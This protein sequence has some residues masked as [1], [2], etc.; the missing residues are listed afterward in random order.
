MAHSNS[1]DRHLPHAQVLAKYGALCRLLLRLRR[2]AEMLDDAWAA[3]RAGGR[4]GLVSRLATRAG[5]RSDSPRCTTPPPPWLPEPFDRPACTTL[6][7]SSMHSPN[8]KKSTLNS[9]STVN[10][11]QRPAERGAGGRCCR[12]GWCDRWRQAPP[13]AARCGSCARRWRT[14]SRTSSATCRCGC[15][16]TWQQTPGV[17]T[18]GCGGTAAAAAS[19]A[20]ACCLP[21]PLACHYAKGNQYHSRLPLVVSKDTACAAVQLCQG[22]TPSWLLLQTGAEAVQEH[23]QPVQGD[24]VIRLAGCCLVSCTQQ[25]APCKH[26]DAAVPA[27]HAAHLTR[28]GRCNRGGLPA[29][30]LQGGGRRRLQGSRR[31]ARRVCGWRGGCGVSGRAQS[32]GELSAEQ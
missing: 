12:R 27:D 29:A 7:S 6:P 11:V 14:S 24:A 17:L 25:Q 32:A 8:P 31:G 9:H 4:P 15:Q 21:P 1:A 13:P 30:A 28:A 23:V 2:V 22:G 18:R 10:W 16:C 5:S 3:M 26:R 20:R 19:A